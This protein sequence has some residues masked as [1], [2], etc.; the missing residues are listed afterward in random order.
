MYLQLSEASFM[1]YNA[2]LSQL[3]LLLCVIKTSLSWL[4]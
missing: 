4:R 1:A 3:R 2:N